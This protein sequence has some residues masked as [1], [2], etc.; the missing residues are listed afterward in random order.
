MICT[1]TSFFLALFAGRNENVAIT[2]K[3]N[4]R[5]FSKFLE[6]PKA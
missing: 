5:N 2:I 6:A 1:E 4:F 3:A